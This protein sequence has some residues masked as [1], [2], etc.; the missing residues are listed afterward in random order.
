MKIT[1]IKLLTL[2]L[3]DEHPVSEWK[4]VR[5][6][7]L[8]R[9]QYTHGRAELKGTE[10]T[11][12][13]FLKVITDEGIESIASTE[14][15]VTPAQLSIIKNQVIGESPFDRE[16][17]WQKLHKGTRWVYQPP[18]WFGRIR[19]LPL[20]YPRE[21]SQPARA[22]IG[23]TRAGSAAGSTLPAEMPPPKS[24]WNRSKWGK[25]WGSTPTSFTL[26]KAARRISRYSPR[27]GRTV[28]PDYDLLNDPVCSYDLREAIEVG[29]VMED[30]D[31]VWLEEPMHEH[32]LNLYQELCDV[33]TIPV[34]GTEMLMNDIGITSQ[35]L[36]Q[37]GTDLLRGN[38]RAGT[39]HV[40]KLAHLAEM[41]GATIELNGTGGLSGLVHA[42]LG[43][44]IDN[45]QFY[46]F[47]GGSGDALRKQGAL[48]GLTNAP[49]IEDGHI[50]PNDLPGWGADWDEGKF[51]SL[52][53]EEH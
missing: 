32:K 16:A 36:I 38:A 47:F 4:L 28:G 5:I 52:V 13:T 11:R 40:L 51:N 26:T 44:C 6:P 3:D 9:I 22:C 53:V 17:I 19:Q 20:G 15:A 7:N 30:L 48:W 23:G 10:K 21:S 12:A 49:L 24:T 2:E 33:L 8:R 34:M 35:W 42:T 1:D 29:H 45:T 41:H 27:C 50:A 18:G 43:C 31:F 14:I 46:E 39:T 37:G 25:L